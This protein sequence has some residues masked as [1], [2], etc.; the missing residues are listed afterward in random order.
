MDA[1]SWI[2]LG[3]S[4]IGGSV[5]FACND[6]P[7]ISP[8]KSAAPRKALR[9]TLL[10]VLVAHVVAPAR[11]E[12]SHPGTSCTQS[13]WLPYRKREINHPVPW[14]HRVNTA[15]PAELLYGPKV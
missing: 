8:E 4:K 13:R 2:L 9:C 15:D 7:I 5:E 12:R 3:G 6:S 10:S 11:H 1:Q 14:E